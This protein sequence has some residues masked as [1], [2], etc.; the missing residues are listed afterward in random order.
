M[1]KMLY[2]LL[3]LAIILFVTVSP[4]QVSA[5]AADNADKGTI[6]VTG[7]AELNAVPDVAYITTGIVTTSETVNTAKKDN[8]Q[9]MDRIATAVIAQGVTRDN[10]RTSQFSLQPIYHT[11]NGSTTS[12]I[13]G[14]RLQNSIT[15]VVDDLSKVSGVM[16]AAFQAGA[17]QFQ[18]LHFTLKNDQQLR[19]KLLQEA[20]LDGQRKAKLIADALGQKLGYK[21]SVS[22]GTISY[23][24]APELFRVMK[25]EVSGTPVYSGTITTSVDVNLIYSVE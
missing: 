7:H 2:T 1:K 4:V 19:D 25:A 9:V 14:Y 12:T 11:D 23:P 13:I 24:A 18:G 17:N 15:I 3:A 6:T 21:V 22:V 10:I 16:D 5:A 20:V 8:D